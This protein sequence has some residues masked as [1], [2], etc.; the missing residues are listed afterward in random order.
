MKDLTIDR[1]QIE[2]LKEL[3]QFETLEIIWDINA[4]YFNTELQTYKLEC[5]DEKPLGSEYQYDEIFYCQ[6]LKLEKQLKFDKNNPKY[7]YKIISKSCRILKIQS[8]NIMQLFPDD[9]LIS[10]AKDNQLEGINKLTVGLIIETDKGLVPAFLLPS[11][12]GFQWQPK[13]DFYLKN[14]IEDLLFEN[15][16]HFKINNCL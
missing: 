5:F 8:V 13:F 14:E 11:N 12:F 2:L 4:F 10:Y 3:M 9:R 1:N 16:T 7:W 6:F 15:L